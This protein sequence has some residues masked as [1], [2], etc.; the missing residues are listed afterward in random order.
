MTL[1][2]AL[3]LNVRHKSEQRLCMLRRKAQAAL[4][5]QSGKKIEETVLDAGVFKER[6]DALQSA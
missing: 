5:A 1:L 6:E 3:V 4:C 2:L